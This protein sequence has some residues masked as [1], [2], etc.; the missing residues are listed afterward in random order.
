MRIQPRFLLSLVALVLV[1]AAFVPAPPPGEGGVG[2]ALAFA[3][4]QF[5]S[6][7]GI[8]AVFAFILGGISLVRTHWRRVRE[9]GRDWRYS[10]VT[11]VSF[12][13]VLAVGLF[14]LGGP[15]GLTGGPAAPDTWLTRIFEA[16]LSPLHA[17]LYS[18]LAFYVASASY[19]AFRVRS[20]ETTVLLGSALAVLL[21]RLPAAVVP[22]SVESLGMWLLKVPNTA[23]QRALMIG[24][25]L[26]VV[27]LAVRMVLGL[28]RGR[29]GD[30]S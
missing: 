12:A 25:A 17:T 22:M 9:R 11:L 29:G 18:L 6:W 13:T 23:G 20:L 27:S 14:K 30:G 4:R 16:V 15:P 1:A 10:V 8:L 2:G 3:D 7:F 5:S 24:V 19:R 21:A 26:G 28:D